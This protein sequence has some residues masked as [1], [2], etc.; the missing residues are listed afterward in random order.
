[1]DGLS[2]RLEAPDPGT[3]VIRLDG[4][5]DLATRDHLCDAVRAV[6]PIFRPEVLVVDLAAVSVLDSAG[7]GALVSCWK[8]AQDNG[9]ALSLRN[10]RPLAYAQLRLTGL[11]DVFALPV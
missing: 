8:L 9:C 6:L 7:I 1:M 4:E 3:V 2:A 5:L 10:P 11:L